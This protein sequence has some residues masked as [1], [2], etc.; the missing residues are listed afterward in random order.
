MCIV[1]IAVSSD[2]VE[3]LQSDGTPGIPVDDAFA[4]AVQ[5]LHVA[6]ECAGKSFWVLPADETGAITVGEKGML[7][8]HADGVGQ[9]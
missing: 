4:A 9:H 2:T 3:F 7:V 5:A 8:G 1:L 6:A